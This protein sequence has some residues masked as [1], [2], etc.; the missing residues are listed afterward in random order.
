MTCAAMAYHEAGHAVIAR[1]Q[2][3]ECPLVV[4]FSPF[5]GVAAG[6]RT[7][8]ATFLA[9]DADPAT[10]L[11]AIKKD[12]VV[13]LAGPCSEMKYRNKPWDKKYFRRWNN[14]F[15]SAQIGGRRAAIIAT[16][17]GVDRSSVIHHPTAEQIA[18]ADEVP[19]E[20]LAMASDLVEAHWPAI[21]HVAQALMTRDR[22]DQAELDRLMAEG[23][24]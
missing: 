20:C 13:S 22:L 10:L 11:A 16:G 21:E 15:K 1:V 4:M 24:A 18:I 9:L 19:L 8:K 5:E 3:I 12:I 6:A 17:V 14:D 7:V 23:L 2:G